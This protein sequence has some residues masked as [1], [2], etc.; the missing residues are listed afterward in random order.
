MLVRLQFYQTAWPVECF[1]GL[2]CAPRLLFFSSPYFVK[3]L[4]H[5]QYQVLD[6][7]T[8]S[9]LAVCGGPIAFR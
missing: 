1:Y 3:W 5:V 2:F 8:G 6:G 4:P 7:C 9:R